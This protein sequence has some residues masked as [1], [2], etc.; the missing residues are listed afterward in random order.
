MCANTA[1]WIPPRRFDYVRTATEYVPADHRADYLR[2][3]LDVAVAPGGRLIVGKLNELRTDPPA[4][5]WA[6]TAGFIV[7]GEAR[8]PSQHPDVEHAGFWIDAQSTN[9]HR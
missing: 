5:S 9:G 6:R 4:A 3:L 1:T 2:H 8:R 7:A